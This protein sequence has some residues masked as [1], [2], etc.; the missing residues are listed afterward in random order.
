MMNQEREP[1]DH[2]GRAIDFGR[3]ADDY[4]RCRPGFPDGFFDRLRSVGWISPGSRALDIGTGTGTLA[5]GFAARGMVTSGMDIADELL[6]AARRT[7]AQ[8]DLDIRFFVGAAEETGEPD[9]AFE[10]VS[11]GQCWWWFDSDRA[12]AEAA[13]ILVPGGRL[14]ICNFSYLPLAGTVAGRT[15]DLILEHNPGWPKAGWRGVHAEQVQALDEAGFVDVVSF[16]YTIDVLFTHEAW[17]GRIRTC[18]GVGSALDADQV[19]QFD[20]DL[21][22][23]LASDYAGTLTIP[24]R[25][26]ATSGTKR[27]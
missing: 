25:I 3:M 10:L 22:D 24:H 26:F 19:E 9:A 7:A 11:A 2:E 27:S 17:R 6:T 23:M 16:S 15:E 21:L 1:I 12:A 13:R 18:N 8:S 20:A 4:E 5:L 14:L